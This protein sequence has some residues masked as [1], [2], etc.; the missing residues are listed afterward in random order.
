MGNT[1]GAGRQQLP[2]RVRAVTVLTPHLREIELAGP[3]LPRLRPRPGAHLVLH[4]PDGDGVARRVY[5]IWR[6]RDAV[7][8]IRVVLHC[9]GGPGCTWATT[10]QPGDRIVVE[11][12]RSKITLDGSAA[13][14]LFIGDETGA[15]PLPAMRAAVPPAVP[16]LGLF[17]ADEEIP[18]L[19][20]LL[21]VRSL[22]PALQGLELPAGRG[23]AYVAGSADLCRRVQ[24]HLIEQRGWH[25]G[26]VL[27][28]PQWAPGHPGFGAGP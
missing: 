28:Q 1:R 14:H 27:V 6:L 2:T 21:Q 26:S 20:P 25:R 7:L 19:A 10:V 3:G 8:T 5:S 24:R 22:L 16:T 11:P 23:T 17:S 9:T 18:G 15:V 4:V 12:P 13:F